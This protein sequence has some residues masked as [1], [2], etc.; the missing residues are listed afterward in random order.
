LYCV[1]V[2]A[3]QPTTSCLPLGLQQKQLR[4]ERNSQPKIN[5]EPDIVDYNEMKL[6]LLAAFFEQLKLQPL[7][8]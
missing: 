2:P 3:S 8:F 6:T 4:K 5:Y 1:N 7:T